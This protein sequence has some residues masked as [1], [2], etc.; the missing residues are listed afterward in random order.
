MSNKEF[1]KNL[2]TEFKLVRIR[3][4]M[5][6]ETVAEMTGMCMATVS[7]IENGSDDS[8]ILSYKRIAD[9]MGMDLKDFM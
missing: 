4:K 5:R 3:K 1:L 9:A 6:R 2:G 7:A 8:K